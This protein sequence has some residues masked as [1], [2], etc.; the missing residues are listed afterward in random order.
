VDKIFIS[1]SP[2]PWSYNPQARNSHPNPSD[3]E[4]LKSSPYLPKIE[5]IS[6]EWATEEDQRNEVLKLAKAEGFDYLIIQ[7]ADEFFIDED[8]K[9]NLEQIKCNPDYSF[10]RTPWFQFWKSLDWIIECR[11]SYCYKGGKP[12]LKLT[13]TT[14]D[15]SM[16]FAI[17]L[18][19]TT[20]FVSCRRPSNIDDYLILE[21]PCFHLSY[22][23]TDEQVE[24]KIRT[25]GHSNQ[26]SHQRWLRY[27]WYG[28]DASTRNLHPINPRV[29]RR[30]L[31]FSGQIPKELEG[32]ENPRQLT[33]KKSM[34]DRTTELFFDALSAGKDAVTTVIRTIR[35]R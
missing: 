21:R 30:V 35:H 27:K 3:P 33:H 8:Y 20:E 29:W 25:Y 26:I 4:I 10:Y 5:L 28:F 18:N 23:L 19:T 15:F 9:A 24:R 22:V 2:F 16:A 13:N 1:H 17:N 12:W 14:T 7:D 6:G 31:P 11:Y 34:T 32:F